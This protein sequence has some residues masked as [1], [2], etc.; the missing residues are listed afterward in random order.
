IALLVDPGS[1]V[2]AGATNG[3]GIFAYAPSGPTNSFAAAFMNGNVG[4]GTTSPFQTLS[5]NGNTYINGNLTTTGS[6]SFGTFAANMVIG[7]DASGN[8]APT[9]TPQVAALNATSTTAT[10]T[11][12]GG[13]TVG[14]SKFIVDRSTGFVGIGTASPSASLD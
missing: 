2:G 12:A 1:N 6:I 3:Y 9:S 4:I 8:L 13:L 10:S 14:T 7:T 5:V 11:F